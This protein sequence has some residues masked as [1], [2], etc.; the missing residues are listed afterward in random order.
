MR[1]SSGTCSTASAQT[2]FWGTDTPVIGPPQWQIEAF[3]TFTIPDE[4]AAHH[5]YSQLTREAKNKIFGENAARIFGINIAAA[6]QAIQG[7]LLY[8]LRDDRNP[9]R[10][11]RRP[12][13]RNGAAKSPL[14]TT[15]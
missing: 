1:C 3:Q 15:C 6:H 2:T 14:R 9:L 8:K 13:E 7:D 5:H 10:P 12:C 4:F 11:V